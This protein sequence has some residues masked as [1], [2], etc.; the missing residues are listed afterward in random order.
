MLQ[1]TPFISG[2]MN[3]LRFGNLGHS[4]VILT[5]GEGFFGHKDGPKHA[6]WWLA[7]SSNLVCAVGC[8]ALLPASF[9]SFVM[10]PRLPVHG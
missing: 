6:D 7:P 10:F 4:V 2:G 3:A 1:T 5:A 8:V 9:S